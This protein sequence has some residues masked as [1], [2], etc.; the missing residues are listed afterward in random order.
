MNN[1]TILIVFASNSGSTFLTASII[2][3]T[4]TGYL[5]PVEI[6]R[7]NEVTLDHISTNKIILFG[8]PSWKVD[9]TE[10]QPHEMMTD[11]FQKISSLSLE[12]KSIAIFGCGDKAYTQFCG[13]VDHMETAIVQLHGTLCVPPLKV[14]AFY[15]DLEHNK[16]LI[17]EWSR[18]LASE[19]EKAI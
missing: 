18:N 10:G 14:D 17:E 12:N 15:F 19:L 3:N 6:M 9:N 13:A 8:S 1:N 4:L 16:L 2:A 11:L 5:H 7:A